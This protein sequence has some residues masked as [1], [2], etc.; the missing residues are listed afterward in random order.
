LSFLASF[1]AVFSSILSSFKLAAALFGTEILLLQFGQTASAEMVVT[2]R[3]VPF[4]LLD[5]VR[6]TLQMA[7][8]PLL[9]SVSLLAGF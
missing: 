6:F 5:T 3:E 8:T 7:R 1:P 2:G 9:I 4:A